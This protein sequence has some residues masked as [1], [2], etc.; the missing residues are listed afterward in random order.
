MARYKVGF[1]NRSANERIEISQKFIARVPNVPAPKRRL[2]HLDELE[3]SL[4]EAT[5]LRAEYLAAQ[6]AVNHIRQRYAEAVKVL[7]QRVTLSA[8]GLSNGVGKDD[9]EYLA[10]GLQLSAPRQSQPLPPAPMA[11]RVERLTGP[12]RAG[13]RWKGSLRRCCY[14][15]EVTTDP[16]GRHGWKRQSQTFKHRAVVD[17]LRS[18]VWHWIRVAGV[19]ACGQGPWS[20]P[21]RVLPE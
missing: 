2:V 17:H 20:V 10:A 8:I 13:L 3:A 5:D 12:G 7:C 4:A 11:L 16:E 14:V 18:A 9:H 6:V 21:M 15:I 19:N 1:R